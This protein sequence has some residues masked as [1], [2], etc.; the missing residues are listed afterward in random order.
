MS[1]N[2][3]TDEHGEEAIAW[4]LRLRSGDATS[5][6]VTAFREWCSQ[7]PTRARAF[8]RIR[9]LWDGVG[10]AAQEKFDPSALTRL[11]S[12][13]GTSGVLL[14]RR[15][16]LGGAIAASAAVVGYAAA[17]PP[18]GLWPAISEWDADYRTAIGEQRRIALANDNSIELNTRTSI[19][20]RL[21]KDDHDRLELISGE[22][23]VK[24]QAHPLEVT[25]ANGQ[26]RATN[27]TFNVRRDNDKVSVTCLAGEVT[28]GCRSDSTRLTGGHRMA[29]SDA[30]FG[31]VSSADPETAVS[32]SEGFLVFHD[33][34]LAAVIAEINRYRPG[35][36]VVVNSVLSKRLVNGRFY[37]AHLDDVVG[38]FR[39]AFGAR[40]TALPAGIVILS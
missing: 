5:D 1:S 22:G 31:P 14:G 12:S 21:P 11:A 20:M 15:A 23:L 26:I 9:R 33:T 18:L 10:P 30:D 13:R 32:W 39:N 24:A 38:K 29:Y 25:A 34:E 4:L 7:H 3:G 36:I 17:Y 27:A 2:G 28:V 6:D 37:L 8:S 35:R 16:F 19:V 40:V